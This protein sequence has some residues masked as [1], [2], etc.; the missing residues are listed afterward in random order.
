MFAPIRRGPEHPALSG[1][2]L[3]GQSF[4]PLPR[5]VDRVRLPSRWLGDV[6]VARDVLEREAD[7]QE[8]DEEIEGVGLRFGVGVLPIADVDQLDSDREV[9]DALPALNV[10]AHP[11]VP[12][13]L[14]RG[15]V[16]DDRA[17]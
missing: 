16:L 14:E 13:S 6:L 11:R 15:D 4:E 9:I 1:H 5:E 8:V 3:Q 12:S 7:L 2:Y 10:L 17:V